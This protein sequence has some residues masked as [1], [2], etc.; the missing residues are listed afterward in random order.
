[1]QTI[2]ELNAEIDAFVPIKTPCPGSPYPW[3]H[4]PQR[5]VDGLTGTPGIRCTCG[6]MKLGYFQA[7]IDQPAP[8]LWASLQAFKIHY[9]SIRAYAPTVEEQ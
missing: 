4:R 7:P 5:V 3:I 2:T 1:M 9:E 6:Y 8:E